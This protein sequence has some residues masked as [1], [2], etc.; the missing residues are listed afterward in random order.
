MFYIS[1]FAFSPYID[2]FSSAYM[3]LPQAF[4]DSYG[5]FETYPC[6]LIQ[7][8]TYSGA[9]KGYKDRL[10]AIAPRL[11]TTQ[12]PDDIYKSNA[13]HV[14]FRDFEPS[15]P[16]GQGRSLPIFRPMP[17]ANPYCSQQTKCP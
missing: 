7:K 5:A 6:N 15:L 11:C 17:Y 2:R 14:A 4:K 9:L 3:D 13:V 16:L 1:P 8:I 12:Q 10:D